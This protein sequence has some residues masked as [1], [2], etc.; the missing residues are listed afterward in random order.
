MHLGIEAAPID[1]I[2]VHRGDTLHYGVYL[3]TD[4]TG[5]KCVNYTVL[6]Q[7]LDMF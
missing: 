2:V 5:S 3:M 7:A 4:E 6:E 1:V